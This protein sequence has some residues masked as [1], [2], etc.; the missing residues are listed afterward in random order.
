M[1]KYIVWVSIN[2]IF[3]NSGSA[4]RLII[5]TFLSKSVKPRNVDEIDYSLSLV[6]TAIR[7]SSQE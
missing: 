3:P 5:F 2:A 1:K 4:F 6:N 7:F